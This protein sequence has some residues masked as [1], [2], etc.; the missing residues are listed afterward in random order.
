MAQAGRLRQIGAVL[1]MLPEMLTVWLAAAL[2]F[3]VLSART[4]MAIGDE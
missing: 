3:N 2:A 4:P 1:K